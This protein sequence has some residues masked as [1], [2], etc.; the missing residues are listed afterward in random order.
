MLPSFLNL[1]T[2]FEQG[3]NGQ[4]YQ[5][6]PELNDS[7]KPSLA[8][9]LTDAATLERG[10]GYHAVIDAANR[11]DSCR[12]LDELHQRHHNWLGEHKRF[13]LA[14]FW[15]YKEAGVPKIVLEVIDPAVDQMADRIAQLK[16][17]ADA[18]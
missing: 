4:N 13:I 2:S 1:T 10:Y 6:L 5:D 14:L 17:R 11:P 12:L 18:H 3:P 8:G 9:L 7:L 16:I 15:R